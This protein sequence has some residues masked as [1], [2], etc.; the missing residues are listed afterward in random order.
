[1]SAALPWRQLTDLRISRGYTIT[2][3]ARRANMSTGALSRLENG[4]RWP[5]PS[6]VVK[7]AVALNVPVSEIQRDISEVCA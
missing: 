5:R 3:L 2:E 7:L 1:M 6:T 4:Y